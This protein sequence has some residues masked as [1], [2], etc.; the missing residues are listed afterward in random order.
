VSKIADTIEISTK[1][2]KGPKYN[3]DFGG[4]V[5]VSSD[6]GYDLSVGYELGLAKKFISH[7]GFVS[8]RVRF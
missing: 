2:Q 8:T 6:K 5:G 1:G 3:M 4:S 7:T